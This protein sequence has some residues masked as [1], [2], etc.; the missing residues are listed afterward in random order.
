MP[1]PYF[2]F[3]S[4]LGISLSVSTAVDFAWVLILCAIFTP[5]DELQLTTCYQL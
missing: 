4:S 5:A 3:L 2:L 1:H